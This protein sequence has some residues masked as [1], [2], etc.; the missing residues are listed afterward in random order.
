VTGQ[1]RIDQRTRALLQALHRTPGAPRVT[2][3]WCAQFVYDFGPFCD[4]VAEVVRTHKLQIAVS[5]AL[6]AL[7]QE[8]LDLEAE[9]VPEENE[10]NVDEMTLMM[11]ELFGR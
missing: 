1:Q 2:Y 7:R 10:A 11:R 8:R 9:K 4:A 5:L 3:R 6:K